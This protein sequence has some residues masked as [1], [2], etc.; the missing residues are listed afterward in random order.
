MGVGKTS[1][2]LSVG[3]KPA[4]APVVVGAFAETL[5][6]VGLVY[7]PVCEAP[8][9]PSRLYA[10]DNLAVV[11]QTKPASALAAVADVWV[12]VVAGLGDRAGAAGGRL[13]VGAALLS[14]YPRLLE[15]AVVRAAVLA[16]VWRL[17]LRALAL[18][19]F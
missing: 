4:S 19:V 9:P 6:G 5:V 12:A 2:A 11:A 13:L 15:R 7:T 1:D 16:V 14:L 10:V 18:R 3:E 8:N 17:P